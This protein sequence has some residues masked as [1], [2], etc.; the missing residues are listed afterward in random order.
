MATLN[1]VAKLCG[2]SIATVSRVLNGEPDLVTDETRKR[3]MAAVRDLRYRP[4]PKRDRQRAAA[5]QNVALIAGHAEPGWILGEPRMFGS[6]AG[7]IEEAATC[8]YSTTFL[9]ESMWKNSQDA[10]RRNY[11]G[12]C[13]G[14]VIHA[15]LPNSATVSALWDRGY[16]FV[17]MGADLGLPGVGAVDV[18]NREGAGNAIRYLKTLGHRHIAYFGVD[19]IIVSAR[20]RREGCLEAA[21]AEGLPTLRVFLAH[22]ETGIGQETSLGQT[23]IPLSKERTVGWISASVQNALKSQP[24]LTAI[25]CWNDVLARLVVRALMEV[26]FRVPYD[27]SVVGFDDS[28]E[29][30]SETPHL[31]TFRQP[32]YDIGR[33]AFQLLRNLIENPQSQTESH[34]LTTEL[35]IRESTAPP[36]ARQSAT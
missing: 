30:V 22:S 4:H 13:D 6:I 8:G 1:D 18:D 29:A 16:P 3:V 19:E 35:I 32:Y 26:G 10:V 28:A 5:T 34:R 12:H 31:T 36:R 7:I 24:P 17:T 23:P 20:E 11:D 14:A 25:V 9:I 2:A 21:A 33:R 27:M 15:P